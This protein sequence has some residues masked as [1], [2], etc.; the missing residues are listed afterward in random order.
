MLAGFG[1]AIPGCCKTAASCMAPTR[2]TSPAGDSGSFE[3]SCTS[4]DEKQ[5]R[6]PEN[7][8]W[9]VTLRGLRRSCPSPGPHGSR[10][11]P[12]GP[13]AVAGQR[14]RSALCEHLWWA[15]PTVFRHRG[16]TLP[17]GTRFIEY[18][19]QGRMISWLGTVCELHLV[20]LLLPDVVGSLR[21]TALPCPSMVLASPP[22]LHRVL[23]HRGIEGTHCGIGPDSEL[24]LETQEAVDTFRAL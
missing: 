5:Q 2:D 17:Q 13:Q 23:W 21:G 22:P 15:V 4:P 12:W 16:R 9:G 10:D 6:K 20:P 14:L 7:Q 11:T 19:L 8:A 3:S 24:L 1:K 18:F